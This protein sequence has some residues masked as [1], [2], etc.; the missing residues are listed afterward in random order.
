MITVPVCRAE[1]RMSKLLNWTRRQ[2]CQLQY[3]L[4]QPLKASWAEGCTC[5]CGLL[6]TMSLWVLGV[7]DAC[8]IAQLGK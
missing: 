7:A 5:P 1:V 6:I 3:Y 2:I 4:V 8:S